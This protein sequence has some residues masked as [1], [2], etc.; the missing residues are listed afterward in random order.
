MA[1]LLQKDDILNIEK[2]W[3]VYA[4][5]P[6][7]FIVSNRRLSNEVNNHDFIVGEI[8]SVS[9]S[10]KKRE[11]TAL[12]RSMKNSFRHH[13][14]DVTDAKIIENLKSFNFNMGDEE[15]DTSIF[16]GK[17]IVVNTEFI[18]DYSYGNSLK[19][20]LKKMKDNKLDPNG[21]EISF[22]QQIY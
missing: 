19:V 20:I 16:I 22:Y 1:N 15:F 14:I 2:G 6:D 4:K 18:H 12:L 13:G 8:L 17:Y 5:I 21:L 9:S 10:E 7:K 3:R 11:I